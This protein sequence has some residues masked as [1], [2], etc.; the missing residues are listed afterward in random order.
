MLHRAQKLREAMP[1]ELI[2][3]ICRY[4]VDGTVPDH[5]RA[6]EAG[7]QAKGQLGQVRGLSEVPQ[8]VFSDPWFFK[9]VSSAIFADCSPTMDLDL[10][11]LYPN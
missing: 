11:A 7:E 2:Q 6:D 4:L 3:A 9:E 8:L 10:S 5:L 1:V